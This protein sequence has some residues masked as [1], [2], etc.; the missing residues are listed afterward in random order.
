MG[1]HMRVISRGF[2]MNTNMAGFTWFSKDLCILVLWT[3]VAS[4]LEGLREINHL[5]LQLDQ[6]PNFV[7]FSTVKFGN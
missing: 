7:K 3:E 4:A 1:T 6:G 2:P 5:H